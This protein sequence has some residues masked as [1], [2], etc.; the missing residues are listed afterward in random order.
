MVT[1]L[2]IGCWQFAKAKK[3]DDSHKGGKGRY[4]PALDHGKVVN[5]EMELVR[6]LGG[7]KWKRGWW[8]FSCVVCV[9]VIVL[10]G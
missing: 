1:N 10:L 7:W 8:R 6:A 4:Q 5:E 9:K 3:G 2:N